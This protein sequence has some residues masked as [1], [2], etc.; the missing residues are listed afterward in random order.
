MKSDVL[1]PSWPRALGRLRLAFWQRRVIR[2]LVRTTWLALLVPVVV[3]VSYMWFNYAVSWL[4]WLPLM[5]GVAGLSLLWSLRPIT[6][7]YMVQRLEY[8]LGFQA[9][10]ITAWEV[11]QKSAAQSENPISQ[12]LFHEVGQLTGQLS[13]R[14]RLLNF[15][16]W[17]EIEAL[18]AVTALFSALLMADALTMRVPNATAIELPASWVEPRAEELIPPDPQLFPPPF[19]QPPDLSPE[20]VQQALQEL[21][22]ALRDDAMTRE[23]AEALDQGDMAGAAQAVRG[24]ADQL[25]Q[26]SSEAQESL[27]EALQGA[28]QAMGAGTPSLTSP[29]QSAG[30]ALNSGMPGQAGQALDDLAEQLDGLAK[31]QEEMAGPQAEG[32]PEP[33][34]S[35]DEPN[36]GGESNPGTPEATPGSS[37]TAAP[38]P[39]VEATG[40]VGEADQGELE[41]GMQPGQEGDGM[42]QPTEQERLGVEG[43]PLD[44][45]VDEDT[46]PSDHVLQP[47]DLNAKAGDKQTKDSPFARP[48]GNNEELGPDPLSYPWEK[49]DV[50][51][52]YFTGME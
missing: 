4:L 38:M 47:A 2:G 42:G 6:L 3:M 31:Q 33:S 30:A 17:L 44:V 8:R 24:L 20:Q 18:I 52:R 19:Q 23:I 50:I 11:S 27:G 16:L 1:L 9:R 48:R 35:Q 15:S 49:R 40:T 43:E 29:L 41:A 25:E 28:A 45:T 46:P 39:T 5:L 14:V 37:A 32:Q 51:R 21:A 34:D 12:R 10:L 26:M 13:R 7:S 36:E 22:D